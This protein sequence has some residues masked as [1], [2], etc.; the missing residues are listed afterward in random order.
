VDFNDATTQEAVLRY[1]QVILQAFREVS[2]GLFDY[3]RQQ[4]VRAE[5][6]ATVQTQRDALRLAN[7]RYE[8][9]VTSFLEVLITERDLFDFELALARVQRDELLAVVRLYRALG[10]GW[11][12]ELPPP[13]SAAIPESHGHSE[14]RPARAEGTEPAP[15]TP[16]ARTA[17][18]SKSAR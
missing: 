1:Q 17:P 4:G 12:S 11:Q 7:L 15:A 16:A 5:T 13:P 2:D 9:G 10:G 3:R 6:E 18:V 14:S 8:G